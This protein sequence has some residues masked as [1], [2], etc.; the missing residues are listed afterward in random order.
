MS[1]ILVITHNDFDGIFSGA[2][3]L[4]GLRDRRAVLEVAI[5]TPRRLA[6]TLTHL[7]GGFSFPD[8]VYI[9]DLALNADQEE[10]VLRVLHQLKERGRR[11]FWYDH[12]RWDR[13][14]LDRAGYVCD[15]LCV[16]QQVKTAAQLLQQELFPEHPRVAKLLRL[17]YHQP[18]EAGSAWAHEW[19]E[20]LEDTV[21]R[22][23]P[24]AVRAAV[25]KLA[26]R[27]RPGGMAAL[28]G[29]F[30][31][32]LRREVPLDQLPRRLETTQQGR[33]L[34]VIDL[35]GAAVNINAVY[36]QIIELF[37]PGIY[38]AVLENTLLQCGRGLD[39]GF[40]LEPLL[41]EDG[42]GRNY[43]VKGHRYV[44]AVTLRP[45]LAS[46]ISQ[47]FSRGYPREVEQFI[48]LIRERY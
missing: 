3:L 19:L 45:S 28:G 42:R 48:A 40:S 39:E 6:Q 4:A 22:R 41:L 34:L 12:H 37:Q 1:R 5:A 29:W 36:R 20:Y 31:R 21:A 18:P 32:L 11:V 17:L 16:N 33:A 30:R 9:V 24:G 35:R 15:T 8:E 25:Y 23:D 2:M 27:E 7:L 46:I 14:V 47:S 38:I 26:Y 10:E 13:A 43:T 44:G